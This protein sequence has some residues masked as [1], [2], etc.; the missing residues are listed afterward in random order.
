VRTRSDDLGHGELREKGV[1]VVSIWPGLVLTE[2]TQ[3]FA[4]TGRLDFEGAE[5]QRFTGRAI[6]HLATDADVLARSGTAITSRELA[7]HYG[8]RDVD[9]GLPKGPMHRRPDGLT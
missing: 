1:T 2:R 9:G 8:F 4:E 5:S 3:A 6:A 7:D